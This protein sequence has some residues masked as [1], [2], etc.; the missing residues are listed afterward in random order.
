MSRAHLA[1][2]D[3]G[4]DGP[5]TLYAHATGFH[6]HCWT[7]VTAALPQLHNIGYD[8]RGHGDTP[9]GPDWAASD[10]VDWDVYGHD[11]ALVAHSLSVDGQVL[12]VGH[13]M[14]GAALVMAAL[15]AP[16]LFC[17]LVLYEPIVMPPLEPGAVPVGGG[18]HLAIGARKRRG[19]FPSF[20][21][22]IANYSAKPPMDIFTPESVEAYVRFGFRPGHD[23]DGNPNVTLKCSPEHEARTYEAGGIHQTWERLGDLAVPVWV[24]CGLPQVGQPSAGTK[25]LAER[26]PGARYIELD[27]LGHFGP[28][29][30]PNEIAALVSEA[31]RAFRTP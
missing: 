21:A 5:T 16:E 13:S 18:N 31:S 27:H 9:V 7:P 2:H 24:V 20:E 30:A 10:H 6:A 25:T 14:G 12:G 26:I 17:G 11:C 8:A 3:L 15:T 28:M 29:Q 19:S 23:A 4:G 1:V 22:A